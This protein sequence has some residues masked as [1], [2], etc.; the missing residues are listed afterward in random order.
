M[1]IWVI[2]DVKHSDGTGIAYSITS[3]LQERKGFL[4]EISDRENVF[5][6]ACTQETM[7][8]SPTLC[9]VEEILIDP[10]NLIG[11]HVS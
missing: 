2:E 10:V 9:T 6:Y 5:A 1:Y 3:G 11:D 4:E 7:V 8:D